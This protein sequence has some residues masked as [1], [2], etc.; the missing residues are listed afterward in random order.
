MNKLNVIFHRFLTDGNG[1]DCLR[2]QVQEHYSKVYL[3]T[4]IAFLGSVLVGYI[5]WI[6]S[7]PIQQ[8]Q[9]VVWMFFVVGLAAFRLML[10]FRFN[11]HLANLD[12][13]DALLEPYSWARWEVFCCAGYGAIVGSLFFIMYQGGLFD[14]FANAQVSVMMVA[15]AIAISSFLAVYLPCYVSFAVVSSIPVYVKVLIEADFPGIVGLMVFTVF[16]VAVYR[17]LRALNRKLAEPIELRLQNIELIENLARSHDRV[18]DDYKNL[19]SV[20]SKTTNNLTSNYL[21]LMKVAQPSGSAKSDRVLNVDVRRA[22]IELENIALLN[23]SIV[24]IEAGNKSI[25]LAK[26]SV[27]DAFERL[28]KNLRDFANDVEVVFESTETTIAADSATFDLVL[29]VLVANIL[30][31]E[32]TG[33]T[34]IRLTSKAENQLILSSPHIND[35]DIVY[36][37][38]SLPVLEHLVRVSGFSVSILNHSNNEIGYC[39]S[40]D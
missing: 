22:M 33:N 20:I 27:A 38:S 37:K 26:V 12:D 1:I 17:F 6:V 18:Q 32:E 2:E 19:L 10:V 31:R 28:P 40:C 9:L 34:S 39:L 7:T 16:H 29:R 13:N 8:S 30:S 23:S 4:A 24:E 25:N 11:R 15:M 5:N 3:T 14:N 35:V 36:L 21:R